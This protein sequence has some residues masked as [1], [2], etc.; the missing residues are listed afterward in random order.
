MSKQMLQ[1][2]QKTPVSIFTFLLMSVIELVETRERHRSAAGSHTTCKNPPFWAVPVF[3]LLE[4]PFSK[5]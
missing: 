4:A 3:F 2:R 1:G 5:G